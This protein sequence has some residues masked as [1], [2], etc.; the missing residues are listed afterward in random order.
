MGFGGKKL[1]KQ[2]H[3]KRK[4]KYEKDHSFLEPNGPRYWG[5]KQKEK[6]EKLK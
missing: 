3:L 5:R 6:E 2:R 4:E 1:K